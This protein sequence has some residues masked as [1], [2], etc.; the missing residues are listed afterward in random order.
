MEARPRGRRGGCCAVAVVTLSASNVFKLVVVV[1][2][3]AVGK[4][5]STGTGNARSC[6]TPGPV[7]NYLVPR[8]FEILRG[9]G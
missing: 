3:V 6:C 9:P 7:C 1:A 4:V 5:S 8:V 2:V